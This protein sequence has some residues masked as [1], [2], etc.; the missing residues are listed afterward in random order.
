MNLTRSGISWVMVRLVGWA[1]IKA[2]PNNHTLYCEFTLNE[3]ALVTVWSLFK[4]LKVY[5]ITI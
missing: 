2:R 1:G 4:I 3:S 5:L